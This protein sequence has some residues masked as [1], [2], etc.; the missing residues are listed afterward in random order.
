MNERNRNAVGQ[1][2][3]PNHPSQIHSTL[4]P[5]ETERQTSMGGRRVGRL[6]RRCRPRCPSRCLSR[7]RRRRQ[8]RNSR[9]RARPRRSG[10]DDDSGGSERGR[11][12]E[13]RCRLN[14]KVNARS[15][16]RRVGG[17]SPRDHSSCLRATIMQYRFHLRG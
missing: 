11:R 14:M 6:G 4:E 1:H 8:R 3:V 13:E 7:S 15:F 16:Y 9:Q 5:V 10:H 12:R 17:G 2:R